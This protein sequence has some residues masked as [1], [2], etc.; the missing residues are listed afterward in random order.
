M[1]NDRT[2]SADSIVNSKLF[3][4]VKGFY[5]TPITYD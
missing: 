2:Q 5:K 4:G 1:I 3:E